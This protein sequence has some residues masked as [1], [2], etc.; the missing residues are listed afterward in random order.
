MTYR[1]GAEGTG[2]AGA[3]AVELLWA[4]PEVDSPETEPET[5]AAPAPEAVPTEPE[6]EAAPVAEPWSAGDE[7]EDLRQVLAGDDGPPATADNDDEED[8]DE[9]VAYDDED[10]EPAG[11]GLAE[12]VAELAARVEQLTA[13]LDEER[14]EREQLAGKLDR[15]AGELDAV[16]DEALA[17]EQQRREQI[18][19]ALRQVQ[20]TLSDAPP[21]DGP[22]RRTSEDRRVSG[23]RRR[24]G[25]RRERP[26]RARD[27]TPEPVPEE[28]E[29][30]ADVDDESHHE[31]ESPSVWKNRLHE[32]A[33]SVSSWS[34]D[35]ID[36]LRAD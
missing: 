10:D 9:V 1:H 32:V 11:E 3:E 4:T 34:A 25:A 17:G 12:A 21:Y 28:A 16:L 26:L 36:R 6:A 14:A 27:F 22:E 8:G 18:E 30:E 7:W 13:E 35:D 29:H 31:V 5:D 23:D 19:E 15:L 20:A 24:T 2:G 33:G